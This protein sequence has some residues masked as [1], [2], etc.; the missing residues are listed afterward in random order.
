ML[1]R[2]SF[3][4]FLGL[5][6]AAPLTAQCRVASPGPATPRPGTP[7]PWTPTPA[8]HTPT[9]SAVFTLSGTDG[10]PASWAA[11]WELHK[12]E[13]LRGRRGR[14]ANE[15]TTPREE[16]MQDNE[17]VETLLT[18][19]RH[20][21]AAL[22]SAT[23][24]AAARVGGPLTATPLRD[25]L[26]A[27]DA[28]TREIAALAL[29]VAG[30][31]SAV[32][33][34][35]ALVRDDPDGRR[36]TRRPKVADRVRAFA[37]YGLGLLGSGARADVDQSEVVAALGDVLKQHP[38]VDRD[39]ATAA[40]VGLGMLHLD[41]A[42]QRAKLLR[43][44]ATAAL[45]DV[46]ERGTRRGDPAVPAQ[47]LVALARLLENESGA[48]RQV[49]RVR[50]CDL[51]RA[52]DL[53][54][55][56]LA[57]S[58]AMALGYVA[59][60]EDRDGDETHGCLTALMQAARAH[61]DVD[62]RSLA[63]LALGRAGGEQARDMLLRS[64]ARGN[65]STVKPWAALALGVDAHTRP[66]HAASASRVL[67]RELARTRSPHVRGALAIALGLCRHASAAPA[68]RKLMTDVRND[69]SVAPHAALA[70]GMV[71]TADDATPLRA[72]LAET[73]QRPR[74]LE[75]CALALREL[76]D[77]AAT[78]QLLTLLA[79]AKSNAAVLG[80]VTRALDLIGGREAVTPL[81][82]VLRDDDRASLPRAFA[83]MALGGICARRTAPWWV[84]LATGIN[85]R[86]PVETLVQ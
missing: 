45:L 80:N 53:R 61:T 17:V 49:L 62:V 76:G 39:V 55:P 15:A 72:L 3:A 68:L 20:G 59:G 19:R 34:L 27:A 81:L 51:L 4:V 47:A 37:G 85:H 18:A 2:V 32:E 69:D 31:G 22:A 74:L 16:A 9:P 14:G 23:A 1:A 67:L 28:S 38:D 83:A 60:D 52:R 65:R 54:S 24:L 33:R 56:M 11:W 78:G 64:L 63:M 21:P 86:A 44:R 84:E 75:A 36:L 7:G 40:A 41:P 35:A 43:W 25:Q 71:G 82:A 30:E 5:L 48:E 42:H 50:C 46:V 13:Y 79:K 10:G 8:P 12:L 73:A 66:D 29:G 6:A 77:P 26:A 58:A 70:L 57:R